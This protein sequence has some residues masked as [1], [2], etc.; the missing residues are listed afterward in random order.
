[1]VPAVSKASF[2]ID[3]ATPEA[4]RS[5]TGRFKVL[6]GGVG[7]NSKSIVWALLLLLLVPAVVS[8][9]EVGSDGSDG[10]LSITGTG[11]TTI[12][13]SLAPTATWTTPGTG[14]GVYD[15]SKWAVVFKYDSV[16]V[17]TGKTVVFTNHPSGAPVVWLV[18]RGARIDGTVNL[19]G[20]A[21]QVGGAFANGGP[22]GFRGGRSYL[23]AQSPGSAGFGPGGGGYAPGVNGGSGGGYRSAGSGSQPGTNYGNARV[24]P[25]LGGSGG[26]GSGTYNSGGG[27]GGGALLLASG[28][29]LSIAGGISARGGDGFYTPWPGFADYSGG[30]AGGGIRLIAE[31]VSGTVAGVSA[32]GG[33]NGTDGGFGAVRIESGNITASGSSN[34]NYT[35]SPIE[36]GVPEIWLP[37]TAPAVVV[38]SVNGIPVPTDPRGSLLP[39]GDVQVD[40]GSPVPVVL[41]SRNVPPA[42]LV[43]VRVTLRSGDEYAVWATHTGGDEALSTW[44]ATLQAL[45]VPDLVAIQAR[46]SQQ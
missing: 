11:T 27:G 42:W 30:G 40:S 22:G 7:M 15:A 4:G 3:T 19:D 6:T 45:P 33:I 9:M 26:S 44:T 35:S 31:V 12:D 32:A 41:E 13:L 23:S 17:A 28:R 46:A 8:A 10:T 34:P 21:Y 16:Y 25:L 39:P 20:Q 5:A 18:R 24:F 2:H 1:M 36:G 29:I 38:V 14:S 37:E 43:K